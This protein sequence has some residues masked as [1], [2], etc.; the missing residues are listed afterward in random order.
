MISEPFMG[1][2]ETVVTETCN[3]IYFKIHIGFVVFKN[4]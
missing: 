2:Q 1:K 4:Q 3:C